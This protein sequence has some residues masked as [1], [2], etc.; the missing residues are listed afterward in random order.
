MTTWFICDN[1]IIEEFV[2]RFGDKIPMYPFDDEHFTAKIDV[3][4]TDGL[5]SWI[6]QYGNKIKVRSPKELKNM[7]IDKTNSILAQYNG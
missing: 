1:S 2:D 3:A 6:M 5:V 7:I 4:I